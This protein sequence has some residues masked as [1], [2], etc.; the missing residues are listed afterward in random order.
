VSLFPAQVSKFRTEHLQC[1]SNLKLKRN[2]SK[3]TYI[4]KMKHLN[5]TVY[6]VAKNPKA[7]A[8]QRWHL[9]KR[10]STTRKNLTFLLFGTEQRL[11]DF[12]ASTWINFHKILRK[13]YD[14]TLTRV[15]IIYVRLPTRQKLVGW[16]RLGTIFSNNSRYHDFQKDGFNL[17]QNEWRCGY[18][19]YEYAISIGFCFTQARSR[20]HSKKVYI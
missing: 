20:P 2:K 8:E 7:A 18:N 10:I 1:R 13:V 12:N 4:G 3:C 5:L 17:S 11:V 16:W 14:K 19:I 9:L 15:G 6:I